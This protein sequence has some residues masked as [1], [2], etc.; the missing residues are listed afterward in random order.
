M[1]KIL[2]I[3]I[4]CIMGI[5][6]AMAATCDPGFFLTWDGCIQ[7][8][9]PY[10]CPG[11][12]EA[13]SCVSALG[14]NPNAVSGSGYGATSLEDC[15]CFGG[16]GIADNACVECAPGYFRRNP[17]HAPCEA[18]PSDQ[19]QP[20]SRQTS[21][22][23][24]NPYTTYGYHTTGCNENGEACTGWEPCPVGYY[25]QNGE[26]FQCPEN[27]TT[28]GTSKQYQSDCICKGGYVKVDGICVKQQSCA[29]GY[30]IDGRAGCQECEIGF[31]KD[32]VGADYCTYC[33]ENMLTLSTGS[34]SKYDC[35][36]DDG[37]IQVDDMCIIPPVQTA[38]SYGVTRLHVGDNSFPLWNECDGLALWVGL[39]G[40]NCCVN[41]ETGTAP[42]GSLVIN[43]DG[44][45]YHTTD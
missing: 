3:L 39:S 12:D 20:N 36:C 30:E 5:P 2:S 37:Y 21:C 1:Q 10:Y 34:T 31:Y 23:K 25:C 40:G 18:C 45:R 17:G 24:P 9:P 26:M 22:L 28:S 42:S 19:Y 32:R 4:L 16:Y 41:L 6:A 15:D 7:C 43:V 38:C 27:M 14:G 11:N 35:Y 44:T 8:Q 33:G 13:L 29:V